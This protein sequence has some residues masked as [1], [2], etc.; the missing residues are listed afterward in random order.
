[1]HEDVAAPG[2]PYCVIAGHAVFTRHGLRGGERRVI[3]GE[4]LA[5]SLHRI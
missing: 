4:A 2:D 5:Q 3:G 1:M